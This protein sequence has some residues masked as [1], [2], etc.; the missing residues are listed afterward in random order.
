VLII[1]NGW[2]SVIDVSIFY[3]SLL[4]H[5]LSESVSPNSLIMLFGM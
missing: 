4:P 3:F 2:I 5:H 1:Q